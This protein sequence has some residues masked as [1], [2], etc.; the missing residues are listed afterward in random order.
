MAEF[1]AVGHIFVG[2]GTLS[3]GQDT[4]EYQHG[5]LAALGELFSGCA[6][7]KSL[8]VI[9]RGYRAFAVESKKSRSS[10]VSSDAATGLWQRNS[11]LATNHSAVS[12]GGQLV[13]PLA[14]G[15]RPERSG[16]QS[17][18]SSSR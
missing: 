8:E 9:D 1:E 15:V 7:G 10:S 5:V 12:R 14:T 18:M 16:S 17:T 4:G 2:G 6:Q 11:S 3:E 13:T